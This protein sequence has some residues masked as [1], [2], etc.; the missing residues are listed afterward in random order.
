MRT[1]LTAALVFGSCAALRNRLEGSEAQSLGPIRLQPL[2]NRGAAFGL[3]LPPE[4][5]PPL[6]LA[7]LTAVLP[8]RRRH[9]VAAGLILGG[10]LSNLW[11]RV[12]LGGVI[13]YVQFP[14]APGP[15]KRYVYNLADFSIFA[16]VLGLLRKR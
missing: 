5:I 11:E 9:P 6:S 7:A 16:G 13:D 2:Q 14:H 8:H 3:P 15:A 1:T 12:R 10:G 4:A